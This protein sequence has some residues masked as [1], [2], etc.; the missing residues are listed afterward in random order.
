[1]LAQG[2]LS[3][4]ISSGIAELLPADDTLGALIHRADMALYQ[5]KESGRN[6]TAVFTAAPPA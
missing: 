1:V 6:R 3:V 2:T 5:A 4:T